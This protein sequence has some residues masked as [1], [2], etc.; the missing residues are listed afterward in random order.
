MCTPK[1]SQELHALLAVG[2]LGG[3]TTFSTFAMDIYMLIERGMFMAGAMYTV[4]SVTVSVMA[5]FA[6]MFLLRV[7]AA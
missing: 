1:T 6:G 4:I 7:V 2:A 3:F 5:F